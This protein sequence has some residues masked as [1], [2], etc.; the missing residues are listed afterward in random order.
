MPRLK[1]PGPSP[2]DEPMQDETHRRADFERRIKGFVKGVSAISRQIL[3]RPANDTL[4]EIMA[5]EKNL[6]LDKLGISLDELVN[7]TI[8]PNGEHSKKL[9]RDRDLRPLRRR[10]RDR[11]A[12][13]GAIATKMPATHFWHGGNPS[14][15]H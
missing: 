12:R 7:A 5:I 11:V 4:A 15:D 9:G 13:C 10:P 14:R 6:G 3:D 8:D 2:A 1:R